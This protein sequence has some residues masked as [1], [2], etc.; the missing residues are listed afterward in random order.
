MAEDMQRFGK[1]RILE[2]LGKGGFATVYRAVDTTLGREVALKILHPQ[3][4]TDQLFEQRFHQEARTLAAL[5]HPHII[6]IY[7]V[8]TAEDRLFIAMEL[9]HGSSLAQRIAKHKRIPWEE[10][11]AL[12]KPICEALDYAH[13]Q[14]V[15]HRDLKPANILLDAERGPLLTDFGIAR[16]MGKTSTSLSDVIKGTGSYIAPEVWNRNPA[17]AP[18]DIY[19]LGC[20]VYELLTGQV[21]FPSESPWEAIDKHY[22]G[23]Q[24][25]AAWPEGVPAEVKAVLDK[26][27]ARDPH[28]RYES[29][30]SLWHALRDLD[31]QAQASVTKQ[32]RQRVPLVVWVLGGLG[33]LGIAVSAA[34]AALNGGGG[35]AAQS[36]TENIST[37]SAG[38]AMP[39]AITPL[40]LPT[41]STAVTIMP[42]TATTQ[43]QVTATMPESTAELASPIPQFDAVVKVPE[44]NMRAGPHIQHPVLNTYPAG[45]GM[46][47][48]GQAPG[49]GWL[50][51]QAP[52][53]QRG[54][55][56][57]TVLQLN[58]DPARVLDVPVPTT[59]PTKT[60]VPPIDTPV[61][62]SNTPIPPTPVTPPPP[63]FQV[64]E[65]KVNSATSSNASCPATIKFSVAISANSAGTAT[66]Q[67][68][69][70]DGT[71]SSTRS[72]KFAGPESLEVTDT[73]PAVQGDKTP[74]TIAVRILSPNPLLSN[75]A[76]YTLNCQPPAPRRARI[77]VTFTKVDV[78]DDSE[79]PPHGAGE[80]WLNFDVNGKT[81]RWPTSGIE[82][83]TDG[84]SYPIDTS[85]I[86]ELGV[87]DT[88]AITVRGTESDSTST[89]TIT[90]DM[91]SVNIR[92]HR[93]GWGGGGSRSARSTCPEGC[94]TIYYTVRIVYLD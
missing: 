19:G 28:T 73:R 83:V 86:V 4:L 84:G 40:V 25:P 59:P 47:V 57:V 76:N 85:I 38:D 14:G 81:A 56:S 66:Y 33:T 27:L 53:G 61:P 37:V 15:I 2:E 70:S 52:D 26:A 34:M 51:V 12:L 7:E 17:E 87:D 24:F 31:V 60:L 16:L 6:T 94:Y 67:W 49:G 29:A 89:T 78:H 58:V 46:S 71:K 32:S 62:P 44:S 48:M 79:S 45:T 82:K 9:A 39:T 10:V 65:V 77:T 63:S 41:S 36:P 50:Q 22:K 1:Y 68:E 18:S 64:T 21:L 74:R 20:I 35:L 80:M 13:G 54:W 8:D 11:L 91:G 55:M 72:I 5:H 92:D 90:D 43:P 3:L 93:S 23:P 30:S 42:S 69:H 88:L 75:Q